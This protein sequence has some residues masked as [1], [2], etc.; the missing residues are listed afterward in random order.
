[1]AVLYT[2]EAGFRV[3][4]GSAPDAVALFGE[5]P[6]RV[7]FSIPPAATEI[8]RAR[9]AELGLRATTIGTAG[10]DRLTVARA[11]DIS[12]ADAGRASRTALPSALAV[13]SDAKVTGD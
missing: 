9:A 5:A 3:D 13:I 1:M 12:L 11:F 2:S 10:G 6:S 4:L 7:A 8:V